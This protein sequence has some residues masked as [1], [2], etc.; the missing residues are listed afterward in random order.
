MRSSY[1]MKQVTL[2]SLRARRFKGPRTV[3]ALVLREMDTTYGKSP[4]G[5][6]WAIL[7][8]VGAI[9]LFTI[10]I[11]LGLRLKAPSIGNNFMLFYATGFLPYT[12]FMKSYLK[13]SKSLNFSKQLLK[14][15]RVT[16]I[17]AI[18]GRLI[19]NSLTMLIVFYIIMGG[20]HLAF[21]ID[22]FLD[23]PAIILALTMAL[24]LGLGVGC[25]NCFLMTAFPIWESVW[26][27]FS[28]PLILL[29]TVIY[30]FEEVPWQYQDVIWYNPLIHVIGLL[31][32]GF[33]P[34]YEATYVS[35]LYV[36]SIALITLAAG[37][38][39]LF[40]WNKYLMTR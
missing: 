26:N 8:P 34:T 19:V 21:N 24:S 1:R 5:Y 13:L 7:E 28:R 33:Y 35:E 3:M 12:I 9:A 25:L 37:I 2:P 29:S 15:P 22:T 17:D 39:L 18:M 31:R 16:Y 30:S 40:R 10:V 14:Y 27:M 23:V 32:R 11:A 20:I 6:V 4:G 36:F 38:L